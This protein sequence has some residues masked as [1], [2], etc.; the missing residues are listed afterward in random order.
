MGQMMGPLLFKG[1]GGQIPRMSLLFMEKQ[2][3][4]VP[5][6]AHGEFR[7]L[8][9]GDGASS[10]R[11]GSSSPHRKSFGTEL[12]ARR[13]NPPVIPSLSCF[14]NSFVCPGWN[15]RRNQWASRCGHK[16]GGVI[17]WGV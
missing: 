9:G 13:H 3:T 4:E 6:R 2:E 12:A 7:A 16:G 17:I 15:S 8:K 10:G 5:S 14:H 11:V 1:G